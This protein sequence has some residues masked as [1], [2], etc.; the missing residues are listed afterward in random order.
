MITSKQKKP[1]KRSK[2]KQVTSLVTLGDLKR[3]EAE[4]PQAKQRRDGLLLKD[5]HVAPSV[6]QWRLKDEDI[7]ADEQHVR[8]PVGGDLD[9]LRRWLK[10]PASC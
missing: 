9:S 10:I 3:F 8:E 7:A 5:I 4:A 1:T 6:F 2:L